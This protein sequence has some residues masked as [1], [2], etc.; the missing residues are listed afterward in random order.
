MPE[1]L[2]NPPLD[3]AAL[4]PDPLAQFEQWLADARAAEMIEPNAM[5]LAS[6]GADG[7]P[8]ARIVLF[9]GMV[10][11]GPTFYTNYD[12]RKGRDL[13]ANPQVALVFWW[14]KLERQIRIEGT[15]SKLD[16]ARS[17][18]YFH[19][20]LRGS[21]LAA[22]TSRQSAV[23]ISREDMDQRLAEVTARFEN[24]EVPCPDNWGGYRVE[25]KQ[26]EFWQGRRGRFH[27]RFVYERQGQQDSWNIQRLEP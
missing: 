1:Y 21:Q 8:S 16:P 13:A 24:Q 10:D 22:Y 6:C 27:D 25:V 12:S 3:E 9:K 4:N 26:F 14:D 2:R 19:R 20:R 7:R 23:A 15:V 17:A 18:E 5:T 11:G